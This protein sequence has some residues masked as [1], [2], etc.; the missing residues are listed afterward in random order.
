MFKM[1]SHIYLST[2][3]ENKLIDGTNMIHNMANKHLELRTGCEELS[4]FKRSTVI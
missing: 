1:L 4:N 2:I 3:T